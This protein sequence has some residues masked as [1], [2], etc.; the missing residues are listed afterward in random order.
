MH[1]AATRFRVLG[2]YRRSSGV[3]LRG[4]T[5][6]V[7][8]RGEGLVG[9]GF[10]AVFGAS[11]RDPAARAW[12]A[13]NFARPAVQTAGRG[14][15]GR[16][17]RPQSIRAESGDLGF[18]GAVE[19]VCHALGSGSA[20]LWAG[21]VKLLCDGHPHFTLV[22]AFIDSK[23]ATLPASVH[24]SAARTFSSVPQF[25]LPHAHQW[26]QAV[27]IVVEVKGVGCI[28]QPHD[29][30]SWAFIGVHS[31]CGCICRLRGV[32]AV[33]GSVEVGSARGSGG[34]D[35]GFGGVAGGKWGPGGGGASCGA[36]VV[37]G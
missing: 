5:K 21:V 22:A 31:A 1:S 11:G 3:W 19:V 26:H 6:G 8:L 33:R 4:A 7:S 30:A 32:P 12:L 15:V 13:R 17:K 24:H 10:G 18:C 37:S 20:G 2:F 36:C 16:V 34:L 27:V 29:F 23:V 25:Q 9:V 14:G 28:A 35:A